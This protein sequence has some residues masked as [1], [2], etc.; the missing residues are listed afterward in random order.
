MAKP[1]HHVLVCTNTRPTEGPRP[2][3][4][5]LEIF[6]ELKSQVALA[7]LGAEI[8]VTRTHCLKHCS[9]GPVV[10]VH[11]ENVWYGSVTRS[12]VAEICASHLANGQPVTRLLMP[13]IP[14][15]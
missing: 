2:S 13:D 14:W 6:D 8:M 1:R 3:C 15:E 5:G 12:D 4:G 9:R 7:E 11:P 10:V